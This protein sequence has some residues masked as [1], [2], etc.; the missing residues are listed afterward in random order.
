MSNILA[1]PLDPLLLGY[2]YRNG[3]DIACKALESNTLK[4]DLRNVFYSSSG[5]FRVAGECF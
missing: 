5:S 4:E 2:A 1:K 3:L